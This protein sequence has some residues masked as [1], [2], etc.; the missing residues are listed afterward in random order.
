MTWLIS[1]VVSHDWEIGTLLNNVLSSSG[2]TCWDKKL[3]ELE[4]SWRSP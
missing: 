2:V 4:S 1:L 3:G